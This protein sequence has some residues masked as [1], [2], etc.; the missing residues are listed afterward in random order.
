MIP[1]SNFVF[2]LALAFS[3]I[4][5][6]GFAGQ[7][8]FLDPTYLKLSPKALEE[9]LSH[10]SSPLAKALLFFH[11][12]ELSTIQGKPHQANSYL[13]AVLRQCSLWEADTFSSFSGDDLGRVYGL[14]ALA[15]GYTLT[16]NP[17]FELGTLQKISRAWEAMKQ[18]LNVAPERC[19]LEGKLYLLLPPHEGRDL[20]KAL[21]MFALVEGMVKEPFAIQYWI[22]RAHAMNGNR[23]ALVNLHEKWGEEEKRG[24]AFLESDAGLGLKTPEQA[25]LDGY[26]YGLFPGFSLISGAGFGASLQFVDERIFDEARLGK[27]ELFATTRGN[28]GAEARWL[29][30]ELADPYAIEV[31]GGWSKRREDFFR[32]GIGADSFSTSHF[33]SRR[34]FST[35]LVRPIWSGTYLKLGWRLDS[36]NLDL[37][38]QSEYLPSAAPEALGSTFHGLWSEWGWDSRDSMEDPWTGNLVRVQGYFPSTN[39]GS[40]WGFEKWKFDFRSY[41]VP[42]IRHG[43]VFGAS[44]VHLKGEVV[45]FAAYPD[46][47]R[48]LNLPGTRLG[49]FRDRNGWGG[50]VEYRR[51]LGGQFWL[52]GY[53]TYATMSPDLSSL[54]RSQYQLGAGGAL[55]VRS[56]ASRGIQ[57]RLEF[58]VFAGE[59][60]LNAGVGAPL[61]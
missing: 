29:E 5:G 55:L 61:F 45:P 40:R 43:V 23:R 7:E 30:G 3:F 13:N 38:P 8:S 53:G 26:R 16:G 54:L 35:S 33:V 6:T 10:A 57:G 46:L 58:G 44:L 39:L 1:T 14:C 22:R 2:S 24:R 20:K 47:S 25:A 60:V 31:N 56:S 4:S 51:G 18:H 36:E 21:V 50:F 37:T 11:W 28:F 41:F 19:Y 49:R 48:N 27:L 9:K 12:Y 32:L 15:N 42:W 17:V 52:A 34:F 59:W